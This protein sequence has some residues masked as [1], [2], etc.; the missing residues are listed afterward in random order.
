MDADHDE[1]KK[2]IEF[3][4]PVKFNGSIYRFRIIAKEGDKNS[5]R[6]TIKEARF[7]EIQKEGRLSDLLKN[8]NDRRGK[9]YINPDGTLNY[10]FGALESLP[11][12]KAS[13]REDKTPLNSRDRKQ[14]QRKEDMYA[15][16]VQR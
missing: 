2:Y 15:P 8:I 6:Y 10:E 13:L 16:N 14:E 7:Y 5:L 9:P 12:G 3:F 1:D 4:I 11:I